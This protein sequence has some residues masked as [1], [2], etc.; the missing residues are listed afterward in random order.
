MYNS[1]YHLEYV[2]KFILF[3]CLEV[4]NCTFIDLNQHL[5]VTGTLVEGY[6]H[7]K[8]LYDLVITCMYSA[9]GCRWIESLGDGCYQVVTN[10]SSG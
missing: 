8:C 5:K 9:R 7:T 2:F 3:V 10:V 1:E 6:V 4:L